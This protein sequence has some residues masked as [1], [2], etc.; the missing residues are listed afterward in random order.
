MNKN[1]NLLIT[2]MLR[3]WYF[4]D[5]VLLCEHA[6]KC[7]TDDKDYQE[8]I[9]LKAALMSD[10][11]EFYSYIDYIP[12]T[13]KLPS[14]SV[15]LQE[16]AVQLA[17][18]SKAISAKMI[19][20]QDFKNHLKNV[21]INE[22]K[23]NSKRNVNAISDTV[24]NERFLKMTLDN[25]LIGVPIIECANKEKIDDFRGGLL[26]QA[27]LTVRSELVQISEKYNSVFQKKT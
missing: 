1:K 20:S 3:N 4:I 16:Q 24:I 11:Y 21:I 7:I 10:L 14:N 18:K 19:E 6:K 27:Y 23:K 26:E 9:S 15:Q 22:F 17:R 2:E 5:S 12:K 25:M 13:N 8:Y